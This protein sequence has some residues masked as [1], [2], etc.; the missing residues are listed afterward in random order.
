MLAAVGRL[1]SLAMM[2]AES[3]STNHPWRAFHISFNVV[4]T[5]MGYEQLETS[6]G[7]SAFLVLVAHVSCSYGIGSRLQL[8]SS[9]QSCWT[10]HHMLNTSL[11]RW[12]SSIGAV[13]DIITAEILI[14]ARE[15]AR[16][17][18][19]S[20]SFTPLRAICMF[21]FVHCLLSWCRRSSGCN[22]S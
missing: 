16:A 8:V 20:T 10:A 9:R 1:P 21:S 2:L 5:I 4:S 3:R 14:N 19:G 7:H 18:S 11:T 6:S 13:D 22:A 15:H 17:L 12:Q